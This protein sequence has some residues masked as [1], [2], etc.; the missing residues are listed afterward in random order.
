MVQGLFNIA[1][2]AQAIRLLSVGG[3]LHGMNKRLQLIGSNFSECLVALL[4][5]QQL[6]VRL[7][8]R[9]DFLDALVLVEQVDDLEHLLFLGND[10]DNRYF[11]DLRVLDFDLLQGYREALDVVAHVH[12]YYLFAARHF[13]KA[14]WLLDVEDAVQDL[15]VQ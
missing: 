8:D 6:E 12:D 3:L 11:L 5:V 13:F 7:P 9:E 15:R 2:L 1:I 4:V 14:T 10:E